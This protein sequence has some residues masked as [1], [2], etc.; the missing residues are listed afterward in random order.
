MGGKEEKEEGGGDSFS[1]EERTS[2]PTSYINDSKNRDGI[3]PCL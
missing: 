1:A 3:R 2:G